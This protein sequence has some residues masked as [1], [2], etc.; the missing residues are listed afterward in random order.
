MSANL[1]S[2]KDAVA[3]IKTGKTPPSQEIK[4]FN[5][6]INW[7]NPSDI[8]IS[9]VL[10]GSKRTITELAIL[11]KKAVLFPADSVL[12]T[13]IGDIGRV[14]IIPN[15]ASSNQ[16]ITCLKPKS[17]LDSSFLYYW[18]IKNKTVLE[19]FSNN[20]VVPI[21]NG[22]S[23]GKI[24]IPLPDLTTQHRIAKILDKA[25]V[26]RR[27]NQEM[28]KKYDQLAQ[29][30]FLEKFGDLAINP[31]NWTKV[32][33]IQT[34]SD[35]GDIKCGPFGSQLHSNEFV[36]SG[37]PLWGIKQVNK[38]F[39]KSTSDFITIEKYR[40][41]KVYNILPDD[42]IMT[43]KGTIGNSAVYPKDLPEGIMH[44][45]LLRIRVN[46]SITNPIFLSYQFKENRDIYFQIKSISSGAIMAGINVTKLK[47]IEVIIPPIDLQNKF[48]KAIEKIEILKQ[49][50]QQETHKSEALF[51][52]LLQR[53]FKGE[54]FEKEEVEV[55]SE[56]R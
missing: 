54:L 45:D 13:C 19:H 53:A 30:V 21:L 40:D 14:S 31:K 36:S 56:M 3:F 27:R 12:V 4:Y 29:S 39:V 49:K 35:Y 6:S 15:A 42:I 11:D 37:I 22:R 23:L 32:I 17:N 16:Q 47:K 46:K 44:S 24:Q 20:A 41:L 18:L 26:I 25:D 2:L 48:A 50:L 8:G 52:S 9:K 7:Y 28:L 5:G 51:Q 33:L 10:N 55:W 34:V 1:I 38:G 43:R